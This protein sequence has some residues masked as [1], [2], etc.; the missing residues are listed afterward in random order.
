MICQY[1]NDIKY[2]SINRQFINAQADCKFIDGIQFTIE[3]Q[4]LSLDNPD[5]YKVTHHYVIKKVEDG[6]IICNDIDYLLDRYG[7]K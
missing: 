3:P 7:L 4:L 6:F 1:K 5:L 2:L